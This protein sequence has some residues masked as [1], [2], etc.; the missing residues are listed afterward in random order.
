MDVVKENM[1]RVGVTEEAGDGVRRRPVI[2]VD[3][4]KWERPKEVVLSLIFCQLKELNCLTGSGFDRVERG[5]NYQQPALHP[6]H[7]HSTD[8]S[9]LH[10]SDTW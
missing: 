5:S 4:S 1:H 9:A 6:Q 2:C 10:H 8:V 3:K 7:P